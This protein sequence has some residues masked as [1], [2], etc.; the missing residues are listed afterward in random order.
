MTLHLAVIAG[1][2]ASGKTG[3]AVEVA[4]K[5]G[6][7]IVSAD[8]RQ[9]YVGLDLGTGKDLAEYA[10]VVPP[11]PYHLIDIVPPTEVYTLFRFAVDCRRVLADAAG[12]APFAGGGTPLLLVGGSGLY[13]EA[14]VRRYEVADV[15]PDPALRQQLAAVPLA[16][17]VAELRRVAPE[18]ATRTDLARRRRV[19][20]ALEVAAA[21]GSG[22]TIDAAAWP[23]LR[24]TVMVVDA[25]PAWLRRRI[26]ARLSERLATGMVDE[27][28]DLLVHGLPPARLD[29]LGLEYREIGR[30]LAGDVSHRE[31]VEILGTRIARF[32]KRQRTWFRGMARRGVA[33][34]WIRPGDVAGVLRALGRS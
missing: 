26:A 34:T 32:A 22:G 20:R 21:G 16:S 11:V 17:L 33:V 4:H 10:R 28:R 14:V 30:Y 27:V 9:V 8:S 5:L 2:T 19:V 13:V 31:M 25:E 1:P 15:A 24:T 18:L 3:L 6:S 12:R 23:A 29:A 7:E